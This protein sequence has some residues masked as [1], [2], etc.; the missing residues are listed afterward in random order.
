MLY[1]KPFED[2]N[3]NFE[4]VGC[5]LECNSEFL[6]LLRQDHKPQGNTWGLAS[7]KIDEGETLEGAMLREIKE[8]TGYVTPLN[9]LKY[10]QTVY[11]R[12]ES[13]EDFIYHIYRIVLRK[14]P[15]VRINPKEHKEYAWVLPHNDSGMEL[16][17]D[18][19]GCIKLVY[20]T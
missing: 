9:S 2:F 6:L 5:F 13:G 16:M 4:A 8:E 12:F 18:L 11:V 7:G 19:D 3:P 14:K 17:E 10:V 20:P 15:E 1:L